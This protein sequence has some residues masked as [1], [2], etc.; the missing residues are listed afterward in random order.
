MTDWFDEGCEKWHSL[1]PEQKRKAMDY[2]MDPPSIFPP[3]TT[4][5]YGSGAFEMPA[6][7]QSPADDALDALFPHVHHHDWWKIGDPRLN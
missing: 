2:L 6:Y 5:G 1:T 7:G 3:G 4:A